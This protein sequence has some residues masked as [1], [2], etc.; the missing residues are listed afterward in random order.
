MLISI[1]RRV[2]FCLLPVLMVACASNPD[3]DAHDQAKAVDKMYTVAY[4]GSIAT[5][6]VGDA[7]PDES[8][9]ASKKELDEKLP[10]LVKE[11]F[12]DQGFVMPAGSPEKKAAVVWVNVNVQFDPGNRALR[13]V[14]GVFGAGKGKIEGRIEAVDAMTGAVISTKSDSD[15]VGMGALGGNVYGEVED[16]VE[17]L[18]EDL[19]E[20]L[21]IKAK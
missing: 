10:S 5:A 13:W 21:A 4:I 1:F 9:V 16:M 8:R 20:E 12:E 7:K 11:A 18:A 6:I 14:A 3:A 19:A 15:T 17:G 2:G